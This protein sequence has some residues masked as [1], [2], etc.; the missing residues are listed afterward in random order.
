VRRN[1]VGLADG[2]QLDEKAIELDDAIVGAPRMAIARADD[3]AEPL[4]E[5]RRRVEVVHRMNDMVESPRHPASVMLP[6][7]SGYIG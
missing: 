5:R 3:E 4:I 7:A 1:P 2:Q 6:L